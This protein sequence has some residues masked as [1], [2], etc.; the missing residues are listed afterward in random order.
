MPVDLRVVGRPLAVPQGVFG[1]VAREDGLAHRD[2]QAG[3]PLLDTRRLGAGEQ[4][5]AVQTQRGPRVAAPQ[6]AQDVDGV[7]RD[8]SGERV[9]AGGHRAA[10]GPA[11]MG[12]LR[13]EGG[14]GDRPVAVQRRAQSLRSVTL[15]FER[16]EREDLQL[17]WPQP[18]SRSRAH[19]VLRAET[20]QAQPGGVGRERCAGRPGAQTRLHG[21][22]QAAHRGHGEG[23][24]AVPGRG[25]VQ[26]PEDASVG[27]VEGAQ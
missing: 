4:R 1:A 22:G 20:R 14:G 8:R 2:L 12:D 23:V 5:A 18:Q 13:L 27:S 26:D 11:Q 7:A 10:Q 16:Q 15:G 17:P 9:P 21:G 25:E 19:G 24:R 3:A 6:R